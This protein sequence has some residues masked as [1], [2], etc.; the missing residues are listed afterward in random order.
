MKIMKKL[1]AL[2]AAVILLFAFSGC[3]AAPDNKFRS[4]DKILS[5]GGKDY[6]RC[7]YR[8]EINNGKEEKTVYTD[9]EASEMILTFEKLDEKLAKLTMELTIK[10]DKTP[11]YA[12]ETADYT[13]KTDRM[14]SE[15]VFNAYTEDFNPVSVRKEAAFETSPD[16]S[17]KAEFTYPAGKESG[18]GKYKFTNSEETSFVIKLGK[19][20]ETFDNEQIY[21]MISS[22][23][24]K[25]TGSDLKTALGYTK[26]YKVF[27][28]A[29]YFSYG[30]TGGNLTFAVDE[31]QA[32][33]YNG[34]AARDSDKI[35]KVSVH[36]SQG[37]PLV[38]Y[39]SL[40]YRININ[41]S[42]VNTPVR[43]YLF[44]GCEQET[45]GGDSLVKT[46]YTLKKYSAEKPQ[47]QG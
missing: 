22:F 8:A 46:S 36:F 47:P 12:G 21:Y 24:S 45:G 20:K 11:P 7:E 5:S 19:L 3:A 42:P 23:L 10:F 17:F 27:N 26:Q 15:V 44:L 39:Y 35:A 43:R 25:E 4:M 6:E 31:Q 40:D 14:Y 32:E 33:S 18:K 29:D 37:K 16:K 41:D 34:L 13:G 38:M 1:L 28:L 2:S 9:G 30:K